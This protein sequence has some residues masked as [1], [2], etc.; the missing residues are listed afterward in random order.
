MTI[1]QLRMLNDLSLQ[2]ASLLIGVHF[3]TLSNWEKKK[4]R[5]PE[6]AKAKICQVYQVQES[7]I[8]W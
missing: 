6:F 2:Q 3:N 1:K 7:E 5:L 4:T 8:Q